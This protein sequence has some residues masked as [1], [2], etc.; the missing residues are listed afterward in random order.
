M[1]K[2]IELIGLDTRR[3]LDMDRILTI[4]SLVKETNRKIDCDINIAHASLW[5][6]RQSVWKPA[7]GIVLVFKAL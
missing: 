6:K 1:I 2:S 7:V 5:G 4:L 3:K